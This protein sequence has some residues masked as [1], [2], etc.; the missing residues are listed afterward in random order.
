MTKNKEEIVASLD[1]NTIVKAQN[2]IRHL[3]DIKQKR[4]HVVKRLSVQ[5][6]I[7]KEHIDRL[8]YL[9]F[10]SVGLNKIYALNQSV[11]LSEII[12]IR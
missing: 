6:S 7:I 1:L 10:E 3:M 12:D 9:G 11:S 8:K 5:R 4:F 2:K